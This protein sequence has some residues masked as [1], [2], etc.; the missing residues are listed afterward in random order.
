MDGQTDTAPMPMSHS[1]I[2][3]RDRNSFCMQFFT[4]AT[5]KQ[6][7]KHLVGVIARPLVGFTRPY[8]S[9]TTLRLASLF[10]TTTRRVASRQLMFNITSRLDRCKSAG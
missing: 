2:D 10:I 9:H 4:T 7:C 6:R 1:S 8:P 3:E 5:L